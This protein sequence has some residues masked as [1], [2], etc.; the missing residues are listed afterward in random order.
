MRPEFFTSQYAGVGYLAGFLKMRKRNFA[1]AIDKWFKLG[2]NLNQRDTIAVRRT[3]SGLLKLICP[4]GAYDKAI[5]QKCREYTWRQ[6]A[7]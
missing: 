1:D 4:H 2:N 7:G 3:V 5:V 6:D